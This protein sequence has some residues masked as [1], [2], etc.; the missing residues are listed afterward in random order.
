MASEI[1]HRHSATAETLYFTIRNTSRQMWNTAGIPNFETLTVAN[2]TSYDVAMTESPASSYFFVGDFP[3]ISGNMVAG[4]YWADIYKRA[5]ASPAIS[6]ALQASY[7][8]YWDGTTFKWW[9]T[10]SLALSGDTQSLA[11][12]KDFA[13]AGYD[14][15]ANKVQGVVLVDTLTAYTNNT[16]QTG[17]TYG[18]ANGASG[19]AAIAGY[20]DTEIAG[21]VSDMTTVLSRLTAARAGYLDKLNVAGNVA[22][23]SE[24]TSIQNNTTTS[25]IAPANILRPASGTLTA[26]VVVY[27]TDEVGNME[28]PDSAPTLSVYDAAGNDLTARLASP[29]GTLT[30]TGVYTW[31]YTS[32]STDEAEEILFT[33]TVIEGGVTR[34]KG[35]TSWITDNASTDFT[36]SDRADLLLVKGY[37][38]DLETRLTALRAG[39]LDNL[40]AGAVMLASS[41]TAPDNASIAATLV[42]TNELQMDW[43]NGGRLDLILDARAS[44][45]SVDNLPTGL[46]NA[47]TGD[48]I[49]PAKANEILAAFIAGKV[50]ASSAGGITTYTYL[51]RDGVT[52]SFTSACSESDGTRASTGSIP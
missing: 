19:F 52:T 47:M 20:L 43:V 44:Q 42:D 14:P 38:D 40:S 16:P 8:G 50:S 3:A 29:T 41:Y 1:S 37:V 46:V 6:D 18:L 32:T 13:D 31:D 21:L 2:W 49:T 28:A 51:R 25:L 9:G 45:T 48:S 27:L 33:V 39:Y 35:A 22:A 30:A 4:F 15:A 17:D 7:F 10:D 36:S 5:G 11:D 26:K 24:V 34:Y 12:L 23:S